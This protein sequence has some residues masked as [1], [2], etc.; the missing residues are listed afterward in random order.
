MGLMELM[1]NAPKAQSPICLIC[2]IGLI[3]LIS[4][5][6]SQWLT[7]NSKKVNCRAFCSAVLFFSFPFSLLILLCRLFLL[8]TSAKSASSLCSRFVVG[9]VYFAQSWQRLT[10]TFTAFSIEF[11]EQYSNLP[12]KFIP[13]AKIFG[14]GNPINESRA[15]SVPPRIGRTIGVTSAS[16]IASFANSITCGCGSTILRIL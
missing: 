4:Q 12:W 5:L 1:G 11:K 15:P 8:R 2:P 14:Q 10:I 6:N 9:S 13:P 7:A 16:T 3:C